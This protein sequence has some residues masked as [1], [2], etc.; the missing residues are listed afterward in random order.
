MNSILPQFQKF[1]ADR[2]LVA[3]NQIPFYARWAS[4]FIRFS[5]DRQSTPFDLNIQLFLDHLKKIRRFR[6]GR[7]R[8]PKTPSNC[9][10]I[11][12]RRERRPCRHL[13]RRKQECAFFPTPPPC[14]G[15]SGRRCASSIMLTAR[16]GLTRIGFSASMTI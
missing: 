16:S 8:R 15:K 4:K 5:N 13:L 6:T 10:P 9:T 1:M 2:K 3:E 14:S 12:F 7:S 11:I